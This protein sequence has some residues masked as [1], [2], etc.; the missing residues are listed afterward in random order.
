MLP[1][2]EIP[3]T[4]VSDLVDQSQANSSKLKFTVKRGTIEGQ[5]VSKKQTS[6]ISV[7]SS[8]DHPGSIVTDYVM[9][10][11]KKSSFVM[12][13]TTNFKK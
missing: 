11:P 2:N 6:I 13:T 9:S 4:V 10:N 7:T 3:I 8:V 12:S 5:P 1:E